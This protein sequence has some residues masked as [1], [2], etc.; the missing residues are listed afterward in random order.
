MTRDVF[1]RKLWNAWDWCFR[2]REQRDV[3]A[4][5]LSKLLGLREGLEF[6]LAVMHDREFMLGAAPESLAS[7][8]HAL[9]ISGPEGT[10]FDEHMDIWP[11]CKMWV[12]RLLYACE[13]ES[14]RLAERAWAKVQK[15]YAWQRK[16]SALPA[17]GRASNGTSGSSHP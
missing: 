6:A 4:A 11:P 14:L 17:Q 16:V 3:R 10:W 9:E 5:R 2:S 1:Q 7:R 13:I 8:V 12:A 15:Q